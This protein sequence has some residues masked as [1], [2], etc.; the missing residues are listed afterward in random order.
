[1]NNQTSNA[2][3]NTNFIS[4]FS[5]NHIE[6]PLI[7]RDYVQGSKLHAEK[8]DA[9]IDALYNALMDDG[10]PCELDFIYGTFEN[11]T[12]FPLDGQQRLTTLYLL[13]W[14]LLNKCR[15]ENPELYVS[16]ISDLHFFDK[17]FSYKT[18]RSSSAFCQKL[19]AF[20]P[21]SFSDSISLK[22]KEQNWFYEDWLQDPS[23]LAML[24][25]L[26]ALDDKYKSL[27]NPSL[28]KMLEKLNT[29]AI[30]F[31]KLDIGAYK[32]TDSL[33]IKMNARGK[34]LTDFENWK[35]NFIQFL[36]E[37]YDQQYYIYAEDNRKN[38][39]HKIKDYFTHS[40]EHQWTDLFWNYAIASY[41]DKEN[42]LMT[43]PLIDPFF[44]NFYLYICR[45]LSSL[46]EKKDRNE[47]EDD[48]STNITE[49]TAKL[50]FKKIENIDFLFRSLDLFVLLSEKN[51]KNISSFF[52]SL[53]YF[54]EQKT[55][56]RVKLFSSEKSKNEDLFELCIKAEATIDQQILLFCIIK[57]CIKHKCYTVTNELKKYTRVCRNLLESINQ[58]LSSDMKMH[59]NVRY[60][61]LTKYIKTIEQ[62]SSVPDVALLNSFESG[63]GNEED[64][65]AAYTWM[66]H[67]PNPHIYYLEDSDY[68]HGCLYAFDSTLPISDIQQALEAFE[69]TTDLVRVRILVAFGYEG[70]N[71]GWCAHGTRQFFGYK[72]RWDV[73]FRYSKDISSLYKA[74]N[75]YV[76]AYQVEKDLD[77]IISNQLKQQENNHFT[78]YFLKYDAFTNS[79]LRWRMNEKKVDETKDLEASHF[80]AIK[81]DYDIISL[82]RLNGRLSGYHTDPY[83]CAVAQNI[84]KHYP[85]IYEHM[86]YTGRDSYK[87][88]ITFDNYNIEL[89][90]E[91]A[92]W[93]IT[94]TDTEKEESKL[95][96][97]KRRKLISLL[98]RP[99]ENDRY[100]KYIVQSDK[101]D[102]I[103]A[104]V[105]FIKQLFE[106]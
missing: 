48:K 76:R 6:I 27:T 87:A 92:G 78:Y 10:T 72:D 49:I 81:S 39:F 14:Y 90:S 94:L 3:V 21:E 23:V 75:A 44:L 50:L 18:R 4:F 11:K 7:Q 68:T 67:Y 60:S 77:K 63:M 20:H 35:A 59:S 36:E 22:I 103:E 91:D 82:Q 88:P 98:C 84:R 46:E 58:R 99:L 24:D 30:N 74:F 106:C 100:K 52:K 96:F 70:A 73:L 19:I 71:F 9:F 54:E 93:L 13:H 2:D 31:D 8:R 12:F 56:G 79:C 101:Q 15:I 28:A 89:Y 5:N 66:T 97:S 40:I 16:I 1:M 29:K 86:D 69:A 42:K 33:Y 85:H 41:K 62:L 95:S 65:S 53:F 102:R 105:E 83:A 64:T 43:T 57:Y 37:N 45:I 26:D 38:N 55:D 34:Q 17:Q 80:F 61:D 104:A 51:N 32:L 47:A 25:M